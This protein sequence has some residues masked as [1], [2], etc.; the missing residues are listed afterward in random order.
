MCMF[1]VILCVYPAYI[2]LRV[3]IIQAWLFLFCQPVCLILSVPA[4]YSEAPLF[5]LGLQLS[6]KG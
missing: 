3:V 5:A 1:L 6:V 4:H 2:S